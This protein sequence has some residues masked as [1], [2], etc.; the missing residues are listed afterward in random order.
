M[1]T[2]KAGTLVA[3]YRGRPAADAEA[4]VDLVPRLARLAD[5][6]PEV[7]ELDLNPVL[8]LPAGCVAVDARVRV[9]P[10]CPAGEREDLVRKSV[11][12]R[13]GLSAGRSAPAR[14]WSLSRGTTV[15]SWT[16]LID[17]IA[18]RRRGSSIDYFG[19]LRVGDD[20]IQLTGREP[21]SGIEVA[22]SIPP[23]E[24]ADV[25][26]SVSERAARDLVVVLELERRRTDRRA[27]G[28]AGPDHCPSCSPASSPRS[29]ARRACS[30]R[31]VEMKVKDVMTTDVRSIDPEA[32]LKEAAHLLT[33]LRVSGLP[34]VAGGTSSSAC[35]RRATS[36]SRKPDRRRSRDSSSGCSRRR[37]PE[38]DAKLTARTVGEAMTSPAVKTRPNRPVSE[39]ASVMVEQN[40]K[41]LPVV[42][43]SG[44]LVGIVTR[45]DLVRAFV[46][47]DR[48]DRARDPRGRAPALA[49]D[50]S[51]L[52]PGQGPRRRG[53]ARA[54]GSR[55]ASR[56]SSCRS[57]FS[58]SRASSRSCRSSAGRRKRT[59]RTAVEAASRSGTAMRG[60][61]F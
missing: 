44:T 32:S 3:G 43:D 34:V 26:V 1:L 2:G 42:D 38:L 58:V 4:L 40:V 23:G 49:L 61:R 25:H 17:K 54:A 59:A 45:A 60:G 41:R 24:L 33:E 51:R 15:T 47:S 27:S 6:L 28:R 39:A 16:L 56:P 12:S 50:R 7:A 13:C 52:R 11:R 31:E 36:S 46:R 5:E 55:P 9:R 30:S 57:S 10:A 29:S 8:G 18:W 22:L 37:C 21:S 48:G 14:M 19:S 35:F 53:P 20:G